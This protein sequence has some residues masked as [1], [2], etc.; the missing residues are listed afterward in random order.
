MGLKSRRKDLRN[1]Q[2]N[3][4]KKLWYKIRNKQF[5]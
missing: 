3:S 2:T 5:Y 1:N 4:E